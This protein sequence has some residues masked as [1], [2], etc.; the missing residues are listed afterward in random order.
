MLEELRPDI[1]DER[2]NNRLITRN[3]GRQLSRCTEPR[4]CQWDY[5]GIA[6]GCRGG[7]S[8][9]AGSRLVRQRTSLAEFARRSRVRV[10]VTSDRGR[11]D[12]RSAG[13]RVSRG[14]LTCERM[15]FILPRPAARRAVGPSEFDRFDVPAN[16]FLLG[17]GARNGTSVR[18]RVLARK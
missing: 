15:S 1:T 13:G 12:A 2:A 17:H 4:G 18:Q 11:R 3:C 8:G 16:L 6:E 10:A 14:R 5:L 7:P 9:F